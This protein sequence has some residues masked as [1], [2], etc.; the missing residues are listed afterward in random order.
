[1]SERK[2]RPFR[3]FLTAIL[4][5][6]P[7]LYVMSIGPAFGLVCWTGRGMSA[8][9]LAY[10]PLMRLWWKGADPDNSDLLA[11]YVRVCANDGFVVQRLPAGDWYFWVSE[12]AEW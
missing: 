1:M 8:A 2:P 3:P 6:L 4:I 9:N 12:Y 7:M 5:G 11:R 10:Q